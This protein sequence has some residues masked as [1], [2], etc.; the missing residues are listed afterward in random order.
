MLRFF[1]DDFLYVFFAFQSWNHN[2]VSARSAAN[3]K[4]HSG[5]QNKKGFTPARMRFLHL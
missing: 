5:T 1:P 3:F 4:I 2:L